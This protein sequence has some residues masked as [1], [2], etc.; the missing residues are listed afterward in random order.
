M[1]VLVT[2]ATGF[3]GGRLVPALLDR[4]HEVVA[5]VRNADDYD[6]PPTVEVLEGDLLDASLTLPP[7]E[8]AY[9]LV[10]SMGSGGDFRERDRTAARTFVEA[11]DAAGIERVL[12]LGGLGDDGDQL[13]KHLQSRREVEEILER[14]NAELTTLRAAVIIGEGSAS[15][16]VV[17]QLARRLPVMVT[18]TWVRT[19]CQPI[20]IDD[21]V[22]YLIGVLDV[23]E[24]V[25]RTFEIGGP[26]VVTY[27]EMLTITAGQLAGRQPLIV[28]VPLLS[29]RLSARWLGLVTDVPKSVARPLVD[30]LK[31]RVVVTDDSIDTYVDVDRTPFDEAVRCALRVTPEQPHQSMVGRVRE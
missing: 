25:G 19:E 1:R 14:G 23:P 11:A 4:D 22:A 15:F 6:P 13:S 18:P 27:E 26:D 10:H 20:A 5:L 31:N 17:T 29:P 9:Y 12:Y 3:V 24:T 30:G 28:P 2:G 7:V 8:A 16:R 21:V